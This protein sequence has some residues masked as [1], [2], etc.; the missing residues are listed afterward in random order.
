MIIEICNSPQKLVQL[1]YYQQRDRIMS[2]FYG[3]KVL[4]SELLN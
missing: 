2:Y 3:E 4:F 1:S